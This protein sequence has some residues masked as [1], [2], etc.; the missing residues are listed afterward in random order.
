MELFHEKVWKMKILVT[1]RSFGKNNPAL[2]KRLEDANLEI[3]RNE[4]GRILSETE[5]SKLLEPCAGIIVGVDPLNAKVL[6][7]APLLRAISKYGVGVDN[8]DLEYCKKKGISVSRTVGAN[9]NAVAD[10]AFA[11]LLAAARKVCEINFRCHQKDWSKITG[12]DVYGKKLGIIGLGSIGKCV[13][14]RA[15]GFSMDIYAFDPQWDEDF[16]IMNSIKRSDIDTICQIS[17]FISLHCLLTDETK[18]LINR[19]RIGLMKKNAILINTARA[20]LVEE[21]AL[22]EALENNRIA[23]AGLDVFEEEPPLNPCWYG[24]ENL[25]MG[26]HTSSSTFGATELMGEMS[27]TNLLKDLNLPV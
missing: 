4:S 7:H 11:L 19:S 22:L 21:N 3:I 20:G 5:I 15:A 16:A 2:F 9:S 26:S 17:D 14:R 18:N 25:L 23:A 6:E 10:Y 24:L 12:L 8:I 13:A 1:P 27:V